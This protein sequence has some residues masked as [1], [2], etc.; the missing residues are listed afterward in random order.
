M[1]DT[2]QAIDE[3]QDALQAAITKAISTHFGAGIEFERQR[4][5][6]LLENFYDGNLWKQTSQTSY[7]GF[8]MAQ[9]IALIKGEQA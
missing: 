2:T 8:D 6:E 1:S 4:I 5:I 9:L 7:V 3:A